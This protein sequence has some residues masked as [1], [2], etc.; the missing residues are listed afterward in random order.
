MKQFVTVI[1]EHPV[2]TSP[3]TLRIFPCVYSHQCVVSEYMFNLFQSVVKAA[4]IAMSYRQTFHKDIFIDAM[5]WRRH[6]HNEMDNPRFT[7]PKMYHD[8]DSKT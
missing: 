1:I 5:C 4:S 6:G 3:L 8:I 7:N 2:H